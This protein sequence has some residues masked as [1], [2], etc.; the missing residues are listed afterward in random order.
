MVFDKKQYKELLQD[1]ESKD[2]IIHKIVKKHGYLKPTPKRNIYA[3]LIGSIIGQKIKFNLA[4]KLRGKLYT[5]LETDN[6]TPQQIQTLG[7]SGLKDIGLSELQSTIIMRVTNY[8]IDNDLQLETPKDIAPFIDLKGI[9]KWTL[10]CTNIMYNLNTD[11]SDFDTQVLYQ[12]LII[13]RGIRKLYGISDNDKIIRLSENWSP[14]RG[15]ITWYL[16]K[17]F[18]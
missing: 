8:I 5:K 10:N 13:K 16:W 3:L 11:D 14:W 15:L 7:D 4:R 18:T 9:G 1:M 6:F 12:D 2:P 17:E